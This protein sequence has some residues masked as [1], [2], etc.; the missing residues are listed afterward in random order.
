MALKPP[1]EVPQGAIRLNTD[2]QK[3]EFFAQDQWWEM[4]TDVPTLNGGARGLIN[5][6]YSPNT[7]T[8][9]NKIEYINI[10]SAANASDFGDLTV[11]RSYTTSCGSRSRGLTLSGSTPSAASDVI[12]YVTFASTGN[13]SDFG[14][15]STSSR[16]MGGFSDSHG[17]LS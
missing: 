16:N 13:A 3:L 15:A 8:H 17:G 1:V 6:G 4:A 5:G 7:S 11:A 9:T 14:D 10:S 2:S 12:D